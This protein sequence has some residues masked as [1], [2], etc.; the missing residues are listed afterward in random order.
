MDS[1][2]SMPSEM[3]DQFYKRKACC[4]DSLKTEDTLNLDRFWKLKNYGCDETRQLSALK[5]IVSSISY[6]PLQA[7]DGR[8]IITLPFHKNMSIGDNKD[9][10]LKR[11]YVK[12]NINSRI[13]R[14]F[15]SVILSL[16]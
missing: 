16:C 11:L 9:I 10:A 2:R 8:F 1:G 14:C 3:K 13:M 15:E 5:H 7:N 12:S 6:K 4:D